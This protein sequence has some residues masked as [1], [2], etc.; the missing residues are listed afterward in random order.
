MKTFLFKI[1]GSFLK[2]LFNFIFHVSIFFFG[3]CWSLNNLRKLDLF[4]V[5]RGNIY[6]GEI[7]RW[8]LSFFL[9]FCQFLKYILLRINPSTSS[10]FNT[11]ENNL[12]LI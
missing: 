11:H 12:L 4:S 10:S 5:D 2:I 8:R 6:L 9:I 7:C 3:K 1:F